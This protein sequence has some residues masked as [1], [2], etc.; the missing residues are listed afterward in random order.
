MNKKFELVQLT[1]KLGLI[2]LKDIDQMKISRKYAYD[3]V[4]SRILKR[5]SKGIFVLYDE[6]LPPMVEFILTARRFPRAVI[7]LHSALYFH[8]LIQ[9]PPDLLYFAI[10]RRTYKPKCDYAKCHISFLTGPSYAYGIEEHILH[11]TAIKVYS[12]AKTV[13]DCF[14]FRKSIGTEQAKAMLEKTVEMNLASF[15]ALKDAARICRVEATMLPL[16]RQ[17]V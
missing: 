4:E 1:K 11:A 13:A 7:N 9:E 12:P 14:K 10:P 16:L 3:L 6:K 17:L 2:S 15:D 8:Q 5:V